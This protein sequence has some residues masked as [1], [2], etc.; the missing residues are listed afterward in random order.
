MFCKN[1][2]YFKL[3]KNKRMMLLK[4]IKFECQ[5]MTIQ[6]EN[7]NFSKIQFRK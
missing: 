6:N 4:H 2:Y 3:I 5:Q 1:E 7:T